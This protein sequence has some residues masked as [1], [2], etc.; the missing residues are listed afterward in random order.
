MKTNNAHKELFAIIDRYDSDTYDTEA[1]RTDA[2]NN[3][4][5]PE[6]AEDYAHTNIVAESL[7]NGQFAQAKR[8]CAEYGLD[9]KEE[10]HKAGL[11][12]WA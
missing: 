2:K 5:S 6:R 9:Y 10:Q 12:P 11:N 8:Q 1:M 4:F 3:N 7:M